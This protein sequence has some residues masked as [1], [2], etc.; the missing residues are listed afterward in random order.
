MNF[1]DEG[2]DIINR[3]DLMPGIND[4]DMAFERILLT[5]FIQN[6]HYAL[7]KHTTARRKG[8][9]PYL[10]SPQYLIGGFIF[11]IL[12]INEKVVLCEK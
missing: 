8:A 11:Y 9:I 1:Q 7:E 3:E 12:I 10:F 6:N 4:I 5:K 2:W